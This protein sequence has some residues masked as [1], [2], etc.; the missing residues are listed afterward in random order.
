MTDHKNL[1]ITYYPPAL[2]IGH[3]DWHGNGLC[4]WSGAAQGAVLRVSLQGDVAAE[5]IQIKIV[6]RR[7]K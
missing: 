7:R 1:L 2:A 4:L 3:Y 6:V 5:D